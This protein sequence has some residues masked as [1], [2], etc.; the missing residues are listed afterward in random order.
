M[1][2]VESNIVMAQ[3]ASNVYCP[4]PTCA[5]IVLAAVNCVDGQKT[6]PFLWCYGCRRSFRHPMVELIPLNQLEPEAVV[7][8]RWC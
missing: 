5:G 4:S 7:E 3:L 8:S 6:E 2:T 1:S